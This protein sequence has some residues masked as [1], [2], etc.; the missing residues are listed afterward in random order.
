MQTKEFMENYKPMIID[1]IERKE[2][3]MKNRIKFRFGRSYLHS[4]KGFKGNKKE[5]QAFKNY[6]KEL[7]ASK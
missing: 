2:L 5:I 4:T 1:F 6:V 7:L 3:K